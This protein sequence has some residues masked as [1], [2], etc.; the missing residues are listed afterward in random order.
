MIKSINILRLIPLLF[1]F[2]VSCAREAKQ[3]KEPSVNRDSVSPGEVTGFVVRPQ[4]FAYQIFSN[5]T[6][7]AYKDA[8]LYFETSGIINKIYVKNGDKVKQ[9]EIIAVLKNEKQLLAVKKAVE[10]RN[11]AITELNSLLL[12]FG[13]KEG[14]TASVSPGLLQKLKSQS[15]YNMAVLNLK[16]ARIQYEQTF[17]KAPFNGIVADL[18]QQENDKADNSKPFCRLLKTDRYIVGFSIMEQDLPKIDYGQTVKVMPVA[19]GDEE[20]IKGKIIEINPVVDKQG[21]IKIKALINPCKD[22]MKHRLLTGMNA[23]VIIENTVPHSLVIP[24]SALVLRSNREV[25]FTYHSGKAQWN[26]VKTGAE[27][28]LFYLVTEGLNFG[29]T[30][31]TRGALTLAHDAPVKLTKVN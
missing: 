11:Q 28:S 23:K 20:E 4:S 12:G 30:V 31:I 18:K 2:F 19:F 6:L 16:S 25:V 29:D 13:G 27:N 9:G 22:K 24:K 7:K 8:A 17:L 15:G 21:L 3:E 10:S 14:D 5:G 1:L 26:Y